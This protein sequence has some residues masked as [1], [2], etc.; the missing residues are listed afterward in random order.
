MRING[1]R[2]REKE[3]RDQKFRGRRSLGAEMR[4]E[5]GMVPEAEMR[6]EA[7]MR[8]E[9]LMEISRLTGEFK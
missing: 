5:T 4:M 6:M 1:N 7:E 9:F 8:A 3:I 2:I